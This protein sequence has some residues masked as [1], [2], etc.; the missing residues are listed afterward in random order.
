MEHLARI[1]SISLLLMA[2]PI[3]AQLDPGPDGVGIYFDLDGMEYCQEIVPFAEIE[4]YL[5][6]INASAPGGVSGWTCRIEHDAT[7]NIISNW[8][9]IGYTGS[10]WTPPDFAV[11]LAVPLPWQPAIHLM[12][13]TVLVLDFDCCWF[14]I[15][16]SSIPVIPE[17]VAYADGA[18]PLHLI[19][20]YQ[21][22]GGPETPV[23]GI[24]CNGSPPIPVEHASWGAVKSLYK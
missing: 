11:G 10:V 1:L 23:A 24:N 21:S 3:L 4:M 12:T 9:A 15:V 17:Q 8:E 2:C 20:M 5:L 22:T 7:G 19:R 14:Y 16:P 13:I 18:D 6:L